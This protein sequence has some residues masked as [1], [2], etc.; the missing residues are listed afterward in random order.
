MRFS[1]MT[2]SMR[3]TILLLLPFCAFSQEKEGRTPKQFESIFGYGC[4]IDTLIEDI[5]E[6]DQLILIANDLKLYRIKRGKTV[7]TIHLNEFKMSDDI[8]MLVKTPDQ[9]RKKRK[10]ALITVHRANEEI[11]R[12][13][14]KFPSG[15][16]ISFERLNDYQKRHA[17]R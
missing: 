12:K 1:L 10:L 4:E 7:K 2:S 13:L 15:R 9:K 5:G 16:E 6:N 17:S 11:A 14:F 8:C 3:L